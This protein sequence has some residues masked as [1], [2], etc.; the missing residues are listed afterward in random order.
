M[1]FLSLAI[2]DKTF[3]CLSA[4]CFNRNRFVYKYLIMHTLLVFLEKKKENLSHEPLF[5]FIPMKI[6]ALVKGNKMKNSDHMLNKTMFLKE[7]DFF[8]SW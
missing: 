2:N 4:Q 3:G 7:L 1:R 8:T 6:G 5:Q